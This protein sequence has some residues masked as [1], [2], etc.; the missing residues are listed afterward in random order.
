MDVSKLSPYAKAV[1]AFVALLA[2]FVTA[3]ATAVADGR[4]E[5]SEMTNIIIAGGALIA[6]V[7]AVFQV[8]NQPKIGL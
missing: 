5:A 8:K 7:T 6:G 3:I 2:T 4:L 1:A